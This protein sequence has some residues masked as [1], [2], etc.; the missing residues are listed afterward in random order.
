[1]GPTDRISRSAAYCQ[2][3]VRRL[4]LCGEM[5]YSGSRN[6]GIDSVCPLAVSVQL[7]SVFG[8]SFGTATAKTP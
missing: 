2:D 1:M 7:I 6:A 4:P 8:L 5:K 3:T